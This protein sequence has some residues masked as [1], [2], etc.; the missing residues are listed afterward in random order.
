MAL[1]VLRQSN[2]LRRNVLFSSITIK[3][4]STS[5]PRPIHPLVA[6]FAQ[7]ISRAAA[8]FLGRSARACWKKLPESKKDFFKI[9]A[10]KYR[11]LGIPG[12]VT[13]DKVSSKSPTLAPDTQDFWW[14]HDYFVYFL[15]KNLDFKLRF[16]KTL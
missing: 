4:I 2:F 5:Q 11:W 8:V 16:Q 10:S 7:P 6:L 12:K 13:K 15:Q 1:S 3:Q 14:G 9:Q